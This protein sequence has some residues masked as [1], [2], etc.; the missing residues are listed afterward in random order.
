MRRKVI[1]PIEFRRRSRKSEK[2]RKRVRTFGELQG[3]RPK[4]HP[5]V[6]NFGPRGQVE[7]ASKQVWV[8]RYT[9]TL[10]IVKRVIRVDRVFYPH[11]VVFV[12]YTQKKSGYRQRLSEANFR[13]QY[14]VWD[15]F[16][17][18]MKILRLVRA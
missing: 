15:S 11:D 5:E 2:R 12:R 18:S 1:Y 4:G 8:D 14:E 10:Y 13:Q 3:R 16:G 17:A 9:Q 7:I 6:V